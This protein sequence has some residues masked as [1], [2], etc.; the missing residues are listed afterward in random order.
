MNK[1]K[2]LILYRWKLFPHYPKLFVNLI[3]TKHNYIICGTLQV[4]TKI[5]IADEIPKIVK[6]F[7]DH[8]KLL[9]WNSACFNRFFIKIHL[10]FVCIAFL[11]HS[12]FISILFVVFFTDF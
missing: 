7:E 1:Y 5:N 6:S 12:P 11:C 8:T 10:H 4:N 3:R 9:V 2:V